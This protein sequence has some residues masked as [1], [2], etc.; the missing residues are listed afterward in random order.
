MK[1]KQVAI[2][3]VKFYKFTFTAMDWED[4]TLQFSKCL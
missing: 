4:I 3:R 2:N 1:E